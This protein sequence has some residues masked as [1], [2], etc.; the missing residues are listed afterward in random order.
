MT[1]GK[2]YQELAT[3]WLN[4]TITDAE[5]SEFAAWYN[6]HA[7]DQLE[8]PT[9]FAGSEEELRARILDKVRETMKANTPGRR[10]S[11]LRRTALIAAALLLVA[12]TGG[13]FWIR[14]VDHEQAENQ[15]SV[16]DVLPG[17]NRAVLRLADGRSIALSGKQSSIIVGKMI[18]YG[19]GEVV[20]ENAKKKDGQ[21]R[22]VTYSTITTPKGGQYQIIL[23]DGSKVWLNSAS[24]L[25][26]P[27][28]FVDQQREVELIEGEAYFEISKQAAVP[29][30]V[31]TKSQTTEVLGTEFN[32]NAYQDEEEIKTT[33]V[34]GSVLINREHVSQRPDPK[35]R[36]GVL[37]VPGEQAMLKDN[38]LQV[39]KVNTDA[40]TAWKDGFFYFDEADIYDVLKQFSRWYD[41]DVRYEMETSD[42]LFVGKIPR[43]VTLATALNVLKSAGVEFELKDGNILKVKSRK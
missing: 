15:S 33:L 41:I 10:A 23:A 43:N 12:S 24:T 9:S 8:L 11:G 38:V 14:N 4:G 31:R 18:R 27:S 40:Y 1:D 42:D 2:R 30:L 7:D 19:N 34:E 13:Y 32:I 26:Y 16:S 39:H 22:S 20:A 35:Q 21:P 17:G 29:F 36:Q 6:A 3:K 37:L 25:Q 28:E 5:K